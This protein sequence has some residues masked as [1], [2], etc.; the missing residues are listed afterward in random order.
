MVDELLGTIF[1]ELRKRL[2]F[3]GFGE[4]RMQKLLELMQ[5]EVEYYLKD[6]QEA[7]GHL[8]EFSDSKGM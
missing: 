8:K 7:A 1:V 3:G 2:A 4:D 5:N 6:S